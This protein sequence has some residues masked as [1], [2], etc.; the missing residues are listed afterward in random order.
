MLNSGQMTSRTECFLPW[1]WRNGVVSGL[2]APK[3][4]GRTEKKEPGRSQG[5]FSSSMVSSSQDPLPDTGISQ[6][7]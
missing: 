1:T 3:W 7:R 4:R 5:S 6:Q 2:Q